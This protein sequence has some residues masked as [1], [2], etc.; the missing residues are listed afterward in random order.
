[1][2]F[3]IMFQGVVPHITLLQVLYTHKLALINKHIPTHA[4]N[5]GCCNCC[6]VMFQDNAHEMMVHMLMWMHR[7]KANT[8]GVTA[9]VAMVIHVYCRSL[10]KIFHLFYTHV[11]G[12]FM[13]LLHVL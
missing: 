6:K 13:Y 2:C 5:H 11:A 10:F 4:F 8:W 1:M 12:V 7:C 3:M 9:H